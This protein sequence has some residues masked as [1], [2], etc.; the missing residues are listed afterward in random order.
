VVIDHVPR[1]LPSLFCIGNIAPGPP[2]PTVVTYGLPMGRWGY[3]VAP[4][5]ADGLNG[6]VRSGGINNNHDNNGPQ[7]GC[8]SVAAKEGRGTD[9]RTAPRAPPARSLLDILQKSLGDPT[10]L[11][12]R[13]DKIYALALMEDYRAQGN[14]GTATAASLSTASSLKGGSSNAASLMA[15]TLAEEMNEVLVP[16][17]DWMDAPEGMRIYRSEKFVI[18]HL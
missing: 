7:V 1:P 12:R 10:L 11:S 16:I 6:A 8:P 17:E 4:L 3:H 9:A 5:G 14:G 18:S 15:T 13:I 2:A